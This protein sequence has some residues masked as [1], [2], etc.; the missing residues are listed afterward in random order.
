M[1]V[2]L[3]LLYMKFLEKNLEDILFE[4]E[5]LNLQE[6]GLHCMQG[7][8]KFRQV[9]LG[10]YGIADLITINPLIRKYNPNY[11]YEITIYELKKDVIDALAFWQAIRYTKGCQHFFNLNRAS[12][13]N[14]IKYNVVII[15]ESL[16]LSGE[17]SYLPSIFNN[18]QLYTYSYEFDGIHFKYEHNYALTNAFK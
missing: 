11:K 10:K 5:H 8:R 7:G 15:G 17:V 16:D 14:F 6:R 13:I 1:D 3:F 2:A 12:L 18:M 4:T 9:R